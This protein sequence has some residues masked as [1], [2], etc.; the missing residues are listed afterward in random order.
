VA[1]A[2]LL[3]LADICDVASL[4]TNF[5][6]LSA[7]DA[8][9]LMLATG[10]AVLV[11]NAADEA[12]PLI[13]TVATLPRVT[14]AADLEL[15]ASCDALVLVLDEVSLRSARDDNLAETNIVPAGGNAPKARPNIP[16]RMPPRKPTDGAAISY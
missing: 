8:L 12:L 13:W 3:A 14:K 11:A 2:A 7:S 1:N 6:T 16:N 5:V 4:I 10:K 15:A 9:L